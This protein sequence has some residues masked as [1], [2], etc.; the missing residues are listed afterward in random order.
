[1]ANENKWQTILSMCYQLNFNI[2]QMASLMSYSACMTVCQNDSLAFCVRH[3]LIYQI[4][5]REK[6]LLS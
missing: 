5:V 6:H 4:I 1:M 3:W 2:N